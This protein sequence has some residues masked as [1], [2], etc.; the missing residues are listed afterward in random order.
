MELFYKDRTHPIVTGHIPP[1][2]KP[3]GHG[4]I[5]AMFDLPNEGS[6]KLLLGVL[7]GYR[8]SVADFG[9]FVRSG[10]QNKE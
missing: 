4:D 9:S 7:H 10:H 3:R 6:C 8:V 1:E 5:D 2:P